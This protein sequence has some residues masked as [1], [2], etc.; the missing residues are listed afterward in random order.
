[1][2]FL[3][4]AVAAV[5]AYLLWLIIAQE[6]YGFQPVTA[7]SLLFLGP[8]LFA[9]AYPRIL[10]TNANGRAGR[11]RFAASLH[12]TGLLAATIV[13][14]ILGSVFWK[15]PLR[16]ANSV[17]FLAA[18]IA[19]DLFFL[20]SA[21]LVITNTRATLPKLASFLLWPC[22][23]AL[24]LAFC[25]HFFQATYV[26]SAFTFLC[27]TT[28]LFL[29]FAAGAVF[30]RAKVAHCAA[31]AAWL[32]APSVYWAVIK[33]TPLGNT[34]TNFNVPDNMLMGKWFLPLVILTIVSVA[35][36][37]LAIATA[38]I[39][40][41]PAHWKIRSMPLC[42]RAWPA[43]LVVL[44]FLG[45]WFSQSVMPYRASGAVDYAGV[46]LL[47]ILH[48]E[49]HGLQFHER[50]VG[51]VGYRTP[52]SVSFWNNDRRLFHYRFRQ[53]YSWIELPQVLLPRVK[54]MLDSLRTTSREWET[55]RPL[56]AWNAEGWY[57][58]GENINLRA[59]TDGTM[60]PPEI[61]QLF[62]D[63]EKLPQHQGPVSD[64]KDVCLGFCYD[65]LSGMGRLY[66]NHRCG[67]DA[68]RRDY[69][70]R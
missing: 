5:A 9:Y 16:D 36:V 27:L 47:Q 41:L 26:R 62:Q 8:L 4:Y 52:E 23:L 14:V 50:G 68:T 67:Y 53:T 1:M 64:Q 15:N 37:A 60:P 21:V 61:V 44:A 17:P 7:Y 13:F 59:Y 12:G 19:A 29:A 30:Y 56:R 38:A 46:P 28:S 40:L 51:I 31:L 49:K 6:G 66:A 70:C 2:T 48:V 11:L 58:M 69:V 10:F 25:G 39:R 24:T 43:V 54:G 20:A 18:T 3:I 34:W 45:V 57:L 32:A 33:D 55:V 42:D 35:L 63:L 65:A 22:W